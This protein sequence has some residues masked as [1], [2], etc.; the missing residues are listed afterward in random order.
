MFSEVFGFEKRGSGFPWE[1]GG[2]TLKPTSAALGSSLRQLRPADF[3]HGDLL[4]E[5]SLRA[6]ISSDSENALRDKE[7]RRTNQER[8]GTGKTPPGEARGFSPGWPLPGRAAFPIVDL[9]SWSGLKLPFDCFHVL[10]A[11][12]GT[13]LVRADAAA[14]IAVHLRAG[15]LLGNVYPLPKR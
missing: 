14:L 2:S 10:I 5:P 13:H 12:V 15:A 8:K 3:P 7:R 6:S 11:K 9:Y 4:M 1:F